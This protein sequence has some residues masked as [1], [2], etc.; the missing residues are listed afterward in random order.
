MTELAVLI[1]CY[2]EEASIASV[3]THFKAELPHA[4]IY[5]YDNNSTDLTV[6]KAKAAGAIV[7]HETR[8]GKGHVVR[9]MFSDIEADV[10]VMVD[11]DDTYDASAA[12]AM[13]AKL[14]DEQ[15]DLVNGSRQSKVQES[16]RFGHRFG[17]YFLTGLIASFFGNRFSDV[18]SGYK[19]FSRRFVKSFPVFSEGF[20]IET[21]LTVHA[22]QL[23]MPVSEVETQ[24]K[25][26]PENSESKLRTFSDG[27]RIL[28]CI[29]Y[30]FKEEKPLPFFGGLGFLFAL[31]SLG[32][33]YPVLIEYL[34]TSQVPRFPTAILSSALMLVSFLC[35]FCGVIL[36]TQAK[37]RKELKYLFYLGKALSSGAKSPITEKNPLVTRLQNSW[38]CDLEGEQN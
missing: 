19:V 34:E 6:S 36:D 7:R 30:L 8:Q 23:R 31:T 14:I 3:V 26:R 10:Y 18:L 25:E 35:F 2:N 13:V 22:L 24:Y 21:E 37:A 9:R 15:L 5:V 20:E 27:F 33:F 32:I 17:N 12:K 11:G 29:S 38:S 16:F 28:K 1:P 4:K